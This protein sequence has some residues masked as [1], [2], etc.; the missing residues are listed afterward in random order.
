MTRLVAIADLHC[1]TPDLPEGDILTISGDLTWKGSLEEMAG[2]AKWLRAQ[3]FKHK[4][5]IAG[6]HDFC[7]ERKAQ[8]EEAET[9]LGGD[10]II[11]L[12]DNGCEV[13]GLKFYG[14]PWQPWYHNWA[15]NVPRGQLYQY[16]N[17]IPANLDVLLVHGPPM[18]FGDLTAKRER[19]GCEELLN[20]LYEKV[21]KNVFYGHIHEDTGSWRFNQGETMLYNCSIGPIFSWLSELSAGKPVVLDI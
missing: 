16:W 4:I 8:R 2:V 9:M 18:G 10:G 5:V 7:L 14:S 15:F 1:D 17:K 12:R 20:A 11:Y 3:P 6:N 13:E 19:A 21:P